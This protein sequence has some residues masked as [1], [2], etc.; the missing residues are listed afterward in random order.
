MVSWHSN[1]SSTGKSLGE[2]TMDPLVVMAQPSNDH[3]RP[4]ELRVRTL[5]TLPP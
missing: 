5:L 2:F 3:G 1:E 4:N